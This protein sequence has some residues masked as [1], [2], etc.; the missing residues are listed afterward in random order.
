MLLGPLVT[1]LG[2][3]MTVSGVGGGINHQ[4][5]YRLYLEGQGLVPTYSCHAYAN[6][7][8]NH[9]CPTD[10]S[11]WEFP[12]S[13]GPQNRR[14]SFRILITGTPK[15]RAPDFLGTAPPIGQLPTTRSE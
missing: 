12:K 9:T 2:L 4:R 13:V 15:R 7:S 14:Q 5:R 6:H 1:E 11:I 8:F 10:T 3:I